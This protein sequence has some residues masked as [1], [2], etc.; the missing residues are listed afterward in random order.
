[1]NRI[2]SFLKDVRFELAKVTWPTRNETLKFT[3]TVIGIS[4]SIAV[5]LGL[6]DAVF[7]YLLTKFVTG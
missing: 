4:L 1:M 5:F 3:L 2:I 7:S 6:L